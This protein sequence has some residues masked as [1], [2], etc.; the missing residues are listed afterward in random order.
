MKKVLVAM[1]VLGLGMFFGCQKKADEPVVV[2]EEAAVVE[3]VAPPAAPAE[4][5]AEQPAE[6]APQ[7]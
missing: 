7:Q 6:A 4:A 3:E 5:P 2:E 1:L